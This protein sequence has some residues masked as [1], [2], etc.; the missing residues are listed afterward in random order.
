M[1]AC[2]VE[3]VLLY[4]VAV[5]EPCAFVTCE[6][7][8]FRCLL[9]CFV[10]GWY[11][12]TYAIGIFMLNQFIAFLTPKIDPAMRD[13]EGTSLLIIIIH[14]IIVYCQTLLFSIIMIELNNLPDSLLQD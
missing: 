12:V 5:I 7:I 14:C 4:I 9:F 6:W 10:Q 3:S 1:E 13:Y 11:I 8:Y 2:R